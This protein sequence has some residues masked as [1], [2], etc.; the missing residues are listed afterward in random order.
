M[1][2]W[3]RALVWGLRGQ[4]CQPPLG[5]TNKA[6]LVRVWE[7]HSQI[8][9]TRG[10]EFTLAFGAHVLAPPPPPPQRDGLPLKDVRSG[11]KVGRKRQSKQNECED[12]TEKTPS[13]NFHKYNPW[14]GL[15]I[16]KKNDAHLL[17]ILKVR[18]NIWEASAWYLEI[19]PE[20]HEGASL[21][22]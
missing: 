10:C 19:Y 2:V 18:N 14:K 5:G 8:T 4:R 13:L 20:E 17:D 6:V 9:D 3:V 11:W 21:N 15:N 22:V 1:V 12:W 7:D 16:C